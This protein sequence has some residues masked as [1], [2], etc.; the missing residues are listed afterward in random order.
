MTIPRR[1][2]AGLVV[3]VLSPGGNRTADAV[4]VCQKGKKIA[5]RATA[6]GSKETPVKIGRGALDLPPVQQPVTLPAPPICG[7]VG[8]LTWTCTV[9]QCVNVEQELPTSSLSCT[10]ISSRGSVAQPGSFKISSGS[11]PEGFEL[12]GG[13]FN[14]PTS[15]PVGFVLKGSRPDDNETGW[16]YRF[17]R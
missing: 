4:V 15:P 5:L 8:A 2:F 13:G 17:A 12:T 1:A 3:L 14:L 16:L 10:T 9:F 6:C 11:C 7:S